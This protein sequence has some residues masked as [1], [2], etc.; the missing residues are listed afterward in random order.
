MK[1]EICR[2]P[3]PD[4]STIVFFE[5]DGSPFNAQKKYTTYRKRIFG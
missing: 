2:K 5:Y 3:V 4:E 1:A